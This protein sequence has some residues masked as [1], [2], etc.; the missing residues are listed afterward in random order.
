MK[1]L[2]FWRE[3]FTTTNK[4]FNT[5]NNG[6][7]FRFYK[8]FSSDHFSKLK[9]EIGR[10]TFINDV[11]RFLAIFDL[12]TYLVLLYNVPF[13]GLSWTPLPTL[14]WD[15]INERSLDLSQVLRLLD[16]RLCDTPIIEYMVHSLSSI[17]YLNH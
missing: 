13:L 14:I 6:F 12:P 17:L 15:V 8:L 3:N 9:S 1:T 7:L 2:M 5:I 4:D 11:P 10:G 16:S